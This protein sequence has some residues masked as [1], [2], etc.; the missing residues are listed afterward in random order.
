MHLGKHSNVNDFSDGQKTGEIRKNLASEWKDMIPHA[1]CRPKTMQKH[2]PLKPLKL[3]EA[4]SDMLAAPFPSFSFGHQFSFK[5]DV[6]SITAPGPHFSTFSW[7][8]SR[9]MRFWSPRWPQRAP[10]CRSKSTISAPIGRQLFNVWRILV[11]FWP[12]RVD[13]GAGIDVGMHLGI[14]CT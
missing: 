4:S 14:I 8:F 1:F 2:D 13:L 6:F 7:I 5:L 9:Q 3:K 11:T 12:S 10:K